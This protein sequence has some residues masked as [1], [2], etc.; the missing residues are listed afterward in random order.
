MMLGT[1]VAASAVADTLPFEG[2]WAAKPEACAKAGSS[3]IAITLTAGRL[4]APPLMD[5]EFTSVLPGGVSYRVE[6]TCDAAGKRGAEFFTFAVL[7]GKLYWT[8]G[9]RTMTFERCEN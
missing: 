9:G 2:R 8:W 5:C 4:A 7:A 6:A 1:L 3:T